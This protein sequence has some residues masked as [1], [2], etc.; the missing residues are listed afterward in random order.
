M[1]PP[2]TPSHRKAKGEAAAAAPRNGQIRGGVFIARRETEN[3]GR[4]F[5]SC[6]KKSDRGNK[7]DFFLW[8]EDARLR[9]VG[10][11][12]SNSRSEASGG[13][14]SAAK[15]QTTLHAAITPRDE[16]RDHTE[17]T[18]ITR[19]ADLGFWGGA[20]GG[21]GGSSKGAGAGGLSTT[22]ATTPSAGSSTL[23]ASSSAN[24]LSSPPPP[25]E[26]SDSDFSTDAE[27]ELADLA[28][29]TSVAITPAPAPTATATSTEPATGSKRK[30][31]RED[32]DDDDKYGGFSSG[33]EEQLAA[34]ADRSGKER[35]AAFTTPAVGA[36]RTQN[37][38]DLA[39]GMPTP[40]TGKPVRRVLFSHG[41]TTGA[42]VDSPLS[43]A[44]ADAATATA[45]AT[46][47]SG[48]TK[49]QRVSGDDGDFLPSPS[50]PAAATTATTVT[51]TT[52]GAATP[53][54]SAVGDIAQ[55][56][57]GLLRRGQAQLEEPVLRDV[58]AALERHAAKARGLERGRDA[59]RLAA[60]KAEARAAE[61]QERVADLE[62]RR[63]MDA[64]TRRKMRGKLLELYGDS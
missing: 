62:N 46:P 19:A 18:P 31:E 22:A 39:G 40:L 49:R 14:P 48:S 10:A 37:I 16:R 47:G 42:A 15:K 50:P 52:P 41:T 33:E 12:L 7:C 24:N 60:K 27:N 61:L 4:S 2:R 13:G 43:K 58:R 1:A 32:D 59:S 54:G 29:A 55:E 28:D 5:Y 17:R 57:M 36:A 11:V 3:K 20:G 38:I 53:G 56:I 23:K 21:A 6:Q 34:I 63:R 51:T 35:G 45:T 30:R 25:P 26:D 8:S 44:T 64:E 9:E